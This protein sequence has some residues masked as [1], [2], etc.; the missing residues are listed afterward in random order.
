[1]QWSFIDHYNL[2][3]IAKALPC[4]SSLL[5]LRTIPSSFIKLYFKCCSVSQDFCTL[6]G[7]LDKVLDKVKG[8]LYYTTIE[9]FEP[10]YVA[11]IS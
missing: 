7:T 9:E 5:V 6:K 11:D 3:I 1:M 10:K 8:V 4:S 2:L